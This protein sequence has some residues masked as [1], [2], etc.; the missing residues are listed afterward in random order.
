PTWY[1]AFFSL[2]ERLGGLA[3]IE[4]LPD[5]RQQPYV[6]MP[7]LVV[8]TICRFLHC[9]KSFRRV[10]EVLLTNKGLLE[11]LGVAPVVCEHGYYR[12]GERKPF[13]EECFSEVFRLLGEEPLQ[14]LLS[15]AIQ[16]LRQ[17][18]PQWFRAGWFVMD[19]NH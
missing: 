7:L 14:A 19:S 2:C 18:N 16:A 9:Q 4:A 8:L 12:N 10:G 11:R 5:P 3:Q 1:D 15:Q 13:N 6:P 17:E